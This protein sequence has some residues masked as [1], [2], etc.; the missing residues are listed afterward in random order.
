MKTLACIALLCVAATASTAAG[1][2]GHGPINVTLTLTHISSR[3]VGHPGRISN[4]SE[5]A[6]RITSRSGH[7]IG[8]MLQQ[9]RWILRH[10]RLCQTEVTL[11]RGKIVAFGSSPTRFE[12]EYAV[13]GGTGIYENAGGVMFINS[14]GLTKSVMLI[15]LI[16]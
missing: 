1:S 11:P 3:A 5:Q 6:W 8:R 12:S 10:A 9:C 13:T 14:I 4:A 7:T 2:E 15:N 16:S